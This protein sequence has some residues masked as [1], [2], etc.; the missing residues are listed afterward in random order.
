MYRDRLDSVPNGDNHFP[1]IA[2]GRNAGRGFNPDRGLLVDIGGLPED[3]GD[4][5]NPLPF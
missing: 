1:L 5:T 3:A 2:K 4:D